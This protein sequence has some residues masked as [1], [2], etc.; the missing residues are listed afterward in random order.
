[1]VDSA[2]FYRFG[3]KHTGGANFV[4]GDGSVRF[5]SFTVNAT[6]FMR[7]CKSDDGQ[8]LDINGL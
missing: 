4:L 1:M 8:V 3:S 5:L 6:S 2:L 7:L